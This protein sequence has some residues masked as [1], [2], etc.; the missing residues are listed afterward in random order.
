[1]NNAT[2]TPTVTATITGRGPSSSCP[3]RADAV[4]ADIYVNGARVGGCTLTPPADTRARRSLA[5]WGCL[6]TWACPDLQSWLGEEDAD[7]FTDQA[8]RTDDVI[9]AVEAALAPAD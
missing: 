5:A 4:D 7:G 6:D 2:K 3:D 8:H 1:M 9:D